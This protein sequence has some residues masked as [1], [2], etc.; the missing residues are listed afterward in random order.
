MPVKV[1]G[2]AGKGTARDWRAQAAGA[3]SSRAK[4][5]LVTNAAR[6]FFARERNICKDLSLWRMDSM[7]YTGAGR[8]HIRMP[9]TNIW[10][11]KMG[12]RPGRDAALRKSTQ[13]KQTDA[14]TTRV[15][16]IA[17]AF[18]LI[19]TPSSRRSTKVA[20]PKNA[21]RSSAGSW[22]RQTL[23]LMTLREKIGQMLMVPIF[24]EFTSSDSAAYREM[25]QIGRASCRERV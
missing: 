25:M 20:N 2:V 15:Y 7:L 17:L 12:Q 22:V 19:M 11:K 9:A 14:P 13:G 18:L 16:C 5:K 1:C 3:A 6:P 21:N 24:G 8:M 10:R 4:A 23:R